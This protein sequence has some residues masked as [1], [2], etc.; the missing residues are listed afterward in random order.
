MENIDETTPEVKQETTP[1]VGKQTT[2][3]GSEAEKTPEGESQVPYERFK[4][5]IDDKNKLKGDLETLREDIKTLKQQQPEKEEEDPADWKEAENRAVKKAV[6]QI[7][8]ENQ[9]TSE[10]E[11]AQ[12]KAIEKNFDQLKSMGQE[13]TPDIKKAVLTK[14]IE[15]GSEDVFGAYLK[16]KEQ[17]VK[18]EKTEEIKKG[19]FV[20]SSQ[21]GSGAGNPG[22]PYKQLRGMSLDEIVERAEE[23]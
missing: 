14:M 5:V 7:R 1:S 3:E 23:K 4:E 18:A 13:I 20:P 22:L 21:K 12:E 16:I 10:Q 11:Q 19:G 9:K 17:T 15:T 8:E 6:T 2:P